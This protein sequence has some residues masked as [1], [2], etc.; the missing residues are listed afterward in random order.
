MTQTQ[1][2]TLINYEYYGPLVELA[3]TGYQVINPMSLNASNIDVY[4]E[5]ILNIFRDGI[6]TEFVSNCKIRFQW[7]EIGCTLSLHDAFYNIVLW[8]ALVDLGQQIQ[9]CNI[10]FEKNVTGG[11]IKSYIDK[12]IVDV[13]IDKIDV[14]R[15]NRA[16][17]D[18]FKHLMDIDEFAKFLGNTFDLRDFV[19]MYTKNEKIRAI[20]D[21]DYDSVPIENIQIVGEKNTDDFL[22]ITEQEGVDTLGHDFCCANAY[23][24]KSGLSPRQFKELALNIGTK[25]D[26]LGSIY[27]HSC[28]TSFINK[29]LDSFESMFVETAS[30]GRYAQ[31]IA[32]GNVATSGAFARILGLNNQDTMLNQDPSFD[33][34][35]QNLIK[36]TVTNKKIFSMLI[37]R[38]Y[39]LH[40]KSC[41]R[42][43]R[44]EDADKLIGKTI[45]LRDPMTCVSNSNGF[46]ICYKCYGKLA[47]V[48]RYINVGKIAAEILSSF[49]T[50]RLL[51][52][53][54]LLAAKPMKVVFSEMFCSYF[55]NE[56]M[57]ITLNPDVVGKHAFL[58]IDLN[59]VESTSDD[60]DDIDDADEA[61]LA[62]TEFITEFILE[63][64][65]EEYLMSSKE[66][67]Q[68]FLTPDITRILNSKKAITD[69]AGRT[70]KA[71]PLA[72]LVDI[73]IFQL[74]LLNNEL[75]KA[76]NEIKH[77]INLTKI[78][79]SLTKEEILQK[80]LECIV[81]GGLSV[82]SSHASVILS[83]LIRSKDD[84]LDTPDW[85][86]PNQTNYQILPLS[87]ALNN[88][89]SVTVSM[90]YQGIARTL[91]SPITFKKKKASRLDLYLMQQPQVFLRDNDESYVVNKSKSSEPIRPYDFAENATP[92]Q[93][94]EAANRRIQRELKE[95][96][97]DVRR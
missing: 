30:A 75:V 12:N 69:D 5:S 18:A 76:L 28:N 25:P 44:P 97:N 74:P 73:P 67:D 77:I 62:M 91:V 31:I 65:G 85:S 79:S 42:C 43:V 81:Q 48:V 60:D 23:R 64:D 66:N 46:G 90:E 19:D 4:R 71:I 6:E 21:Y 57:I 89:P 96:E 41:D 27:G 58:K 16:I 15:L 56:E 95:M 53:K 87:S 20:M 82:H 29:G 8:R 88:H 32:K 40:E 14:L 37:G 17:Y 94:R 10:F 61:A 52:A 36:F 34:R 33:C 54:H 9:P 3:N 93:R 39:R 55:S 51:S 22:N 45:W 1:T 59:T 72:E 7:P 84:I 47:Y 24:A 49:L 2:S 38:Y 68:L 86:V 13:Y 50:Q 63:V 92:K 83:N 26:G 80:F 78:T 11:S 70:I 35:T